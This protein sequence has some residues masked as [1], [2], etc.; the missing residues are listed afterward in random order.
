MRCRT[1]EASERIETHQKERIQTQLIN[2]EQQLEAHERILR[3]YQAQIQATERMI[4]TYRGKLQEKEKHISSLNLELNR[5]AQIIQ[6]LQNNDRNK[7]LLI[8]KYREVYEQ[9]QKCEVE[10]QT[11]KETIQR[12]EIEK[13]QARNYIQHLKVEG[14][15]LISAVEKAYAKMKDVS[16]TLSPYT[17]QVIINDIKEAQQALHP[18]IVAFRQFDEQDIGARK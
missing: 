9:H 16:N 15:N 11:K 14:L 3:E 6:T 12:L 1:A 13:E 17:S 4:S 7:N 5:V 10:A 18:Y 8:E 2:S